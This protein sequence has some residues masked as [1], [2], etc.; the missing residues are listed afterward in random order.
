MSKT[1]PYKTIANNAEFVT[2]LN[3]CTLQYNIYCD[4]SLFLILTKT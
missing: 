3:D 1:R 2:I 4:D